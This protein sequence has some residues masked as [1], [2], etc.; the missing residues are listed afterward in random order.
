LDTSFWGVVDR[1]ASGIPA[2]AENQKAETIVG[3]KTLPMTKWFP[4]FATGTHV[5]SAGNTRTWTEQDIDTIVSLNASRLGEVPAVV[6]HPKTDDPA[7]GWLGG[8]RK[9]VVDG[10]TMLFAR[11]K[12]V[13][14]EFADQ[15]GAG[16]FKKV[17]LSLWEDLR[18]KHIGFLGAV[19]PAVE[20]LAPVAFARH[21]GE[22][23][24]VVMEFV[25]EAGPRTR[26]IL[27]DVVGVLGKIRD[28]V[29]ARDGLDEANQVVSPDLLKWLYTDI[30]ALKP[31]PSPAQGT[32]QYNKTAGGSMGLEELQAQVAELTGKVTEF[33]GRI[34]ALETEN[35]T[36]K[37]E[38]DA[39]K[40]AASTAA[41]E[42][43]RTAAAEFAQGL[44]SEGRLLPAQHDTVVGVLEILGAAEPYE[45][46]S[47]RTES[48]AEA[49][50]GL[51]GAYPKQI[52]FEAAATKDKAATPGDNTNT[53]EIV[54][55]ATE[56]RTQQAKAGIE[57]SYADAV[58]HV[59]DGG[60]A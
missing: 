13:V 42:A 17:S 28:Y 20:G 39:L 33:S 31:E 23:R 2:P 21:E 7:F 58:A 41:K 3:I 5:D 1:S 55:R 54:R 38:N 47:E 43:R 51:L 6:G 19:P 37:T 29:L 26:S 35:T 10:K 25:D 49:F 56:Y 9:A 57:V 52:N 4:V 36:L 32:A 45:F 18:L 34:T 59:T 30:D 27:T 8:L 53:R 48:P 46:S 11:L 22:A 15:V 60:Q 44:V 24:E 16:M 40:S 12:D 14:Q 50:K